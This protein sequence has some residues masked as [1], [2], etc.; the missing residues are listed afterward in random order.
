V[1]D[2]ARHLAEIGLNKQYTSKSKALKV[3]VY[4]EMST[5]DS[6][7]LPDLSGR[8]SLRE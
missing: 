2:P 5:V 6:F 8:A 4:P 3:F 1:I 7:P